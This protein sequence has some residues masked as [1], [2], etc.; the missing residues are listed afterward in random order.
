MLRNQSV[1]K[2]HSS[3]IT[4]KTDFKKNCFPL[5]TNIM[6]NIPT[7]SL[8]VRDTKLSVNWNKFKLFI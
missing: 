5:E 1:W 7:L 8:K 3:T 4:N 2:N 6:K